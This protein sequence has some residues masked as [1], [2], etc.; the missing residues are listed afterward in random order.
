MSQIRD[1]NNNT[2]EERENIRAN[3]VMVLKCYTYFSA[4]CCLATLTIMLVI[5]KAMVHYELPD[6]QV[7]YEIMMITTTTF[8]SFVVGFG[9]SLLGLSAL[10][11]K[12][13]GYL[14][15]TYAI[16]IWLFTMSCVEPFATTWREASAIFVKFLISLAIVLISFRDV[17]RVH[18]NDY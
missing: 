13:H 11:S 2:V 7:F 3:A 16:W 10:F 8:C 14:Y 15:F 9:A 6:F 18:I 5:Q 4:F 17:I 1:S 12:K